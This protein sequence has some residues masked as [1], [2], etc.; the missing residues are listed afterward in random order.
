[1]STPTKS[2]QSAPEGWPLALPQ[3][4]P[5]RLADAGEGLAD[6]PARRLEEHADA[7][8]VVVLRHR[9]PLLHQVHGVPGRGR[10]RVAHGLRAPGPGASALTAETPWFVGAAVFS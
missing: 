6:E 3:A 5:G 7:V 1:M 4:P 10:Q 9:G 8:G 2:I